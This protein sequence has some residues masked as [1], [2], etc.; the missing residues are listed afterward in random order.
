MQ[1]LLPSA[2]FLLALSGVFYLGAFVCALG[3]F[4]RQGVL[5]H[6]FWVLGFCVQGAGL[7]LTGVAAHA[8]PLS[9]AFEIL[10]AIT[11]C[12]VAMALLL[13]VFYRVRALGFFVT[14]LAVLLCALSWLLP[15]HGEST[16]SFFAGEP[17]LGLHVILGIL[18]YGLFV[19]AALAGFLYLL[20]N[21]AL[22]GKRG[23][24]LSRLLPSLKTLEGIQ[25]FLVPLGLGVLA[26]S[27]L[28][29]IFY[30]ADLPEFRQLDFLKLLLTAC[31]WMG[32]LLLYIFKRLGKLSALMFARGILAVCLLALASIWTL[33]GSARVAEPPPHSQS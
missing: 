23:G 28:L 13:R 20:Q 26:L 4:A 19:L 27:L 10:Q 25:L 2:P 17:L 7:F 31:V 1:A 21:A 9:G 18:A 3:R 14:G 12:A 8:L 29:G 5:F 16:P 22:R 32:F 11:W 30:W 33:G 24:G 6:T 15:R